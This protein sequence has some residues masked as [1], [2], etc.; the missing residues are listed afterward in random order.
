MHLGR[1][2]ANKCGSFS[3]NLAVNAPDAYFI[4]GLSSPGVGDNRNEQETCIKTGNWH[5]V[6]RFSWGRVGRQY[7]STPSLSDAR[8]GYMKTSPLT[9]SRDS[10]NSFALG[11]ESD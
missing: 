4:G 2:M 11:G 7:P 8:R 5:S 3:R 9:I 1:G 10:D 6:Y